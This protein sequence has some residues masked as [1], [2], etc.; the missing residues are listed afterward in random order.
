MNERKERALIC[1]AFDVGLSGLKGDPFLARRVLAEAEKAAPARRKKR[2]PAMLIAAL[3]LT[4][5]TAYAV[6]RGL[7]SPRVDAKRLANQALEEKYGLT[8][9][10]LGFFSQDSQ[11]ND[12][13]HWRVTY[14]RGDELGEKLGSYLVRVTD[15]QV[16]SVSWTL[17]GKDTTGGFDA[18]AWGAEQLGEMVK[19]T[20][21][22]H[23]MNRFYQKIRGENVDLYGGMDE[24]DAPA[25]ETEEWMQ[26]TDAEIQAQADQ[27]MKGLQ[28]AGKASEERSAFTREELV[29]LGRQGVIDAYGLNGEQQERLQFEDTVFFP[30]YFSA[31]HPD[32]HP[33]FHMTFQSLAEDGWQEGDG[34]YTVE[35]NA[36]DGTVEYLDYDTTLD[37]NG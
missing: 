10:M 37:G 30:A 19:I 32:G 25:A 24:A 13:Q 20:A 22:T 33:V 29:G 36:L 11:G 2:L 35:V 8:A 34:I 4:A 14:D 18:E 26:E 17:E 6:G 27:L 21:A 3:V 31:G 1:R 15:G 12:G 23:D 16:E 5:V 28:E 9:A 7:L